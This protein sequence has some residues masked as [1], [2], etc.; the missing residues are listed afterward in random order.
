MSQLDPVPANA[1]QTTSQVAP[2]STATLEAAASLLSSLAIFLS[3]HQHH[4]TPDAIGASLGKV[5]NE[6]KPRDLLKALYERGFHAGYRN[7]APSQ[8]PQVL[9]PAIVTLKD[10]GALV[11]RAWDQQG[12]AIVRLAEIPQ[13]DVRFSKQELDQL[14]HGPVLFGR[15]IADTQPT[16]TKL[17]TYHQHWFWSIL[18]RFKRVF[19]EMLG[20]S[21]FINLLQVAVPLFIMQVYDRVIPN[22]ATA[23]LYALLI[24]IAILLVFDFLLRNLRSVIINHASMRTDQLLSALVFKQLMGA[25]L[26]KQRTA[27]GIAASQT[28]NLDTLREFFSGGLFLL[29][30]DLPFFIIFIWLVGILAG[31][32]ALI[33][34]SAAII[35]LSVSYFTSHMMYRCSKAVIE[36]SADKHALLV[37]SLANLDTVKLNR[38]ENRLAQRWEN[39][40][41]HTA[42]AARKEKT[43]NSIATHIGTTTNQIALVSLVSVGAI[44]VIDGMMTVGA[45]IACIIL[46][47]RGLAPIQGLAQALTRI[48]QSKIALQQLDNYMQQPLERIPLSDRVH[49]GTLQGAIHWEEVD[50]RY[51]EESDF[52][53]KQANLSIRPGECIGI[54]GNNGSGKS[55]FGKLLL[56][57]F[58]PDAGRISIDGVDT[59]NI[60]VYE[61]RGQ[62]A[63]IQQD[64]TLF[65]G[66]IRDNLTAAASHISDD[67]IRSV[68]KLTGVDEFVARLAKGY[69][70][71]IS[72]GGLSL[73]TGIRQRIA[74]ARALLSDAKILV[75]DEISSALDQTGE[76]KIVHA[77]KQFARGRTVIVISHRPAL[78]A[79]S[80]RIFLLDAGKFK[81]VTP[82]QSKTSASTRPG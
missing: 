32:L 41:F 81:E 79:L 61:L 33:P 72:E 31:W 59:R 73:S 25:R 75:L 44:Q 40:V 10:G 18:F 29:L 49:P 56:H 26:P 4:E 71:Q 14:A 77:I 7:R 46:T 74:I 38:M 50:F 53:F 16:E 39:R 24:G 80:Q 1:N 6:L 42:Q 35:V 52:I 62:I 22:A 54:I 36:F 30:V 17:P 78:L 66:S 43:W 11:L 67:F 34:L 28:K 21:L 76:Q 82:T 27:I 70:T 13:R 63:L 51:S 69:D 65:Q 68:A 23:T 57:L 47:G 58:T 20:A 3:L 2:S 19:A 12:N 15:P 60:D 64:V 48:Q 8:L 37:E 9:L 5:R 45:L 55:T